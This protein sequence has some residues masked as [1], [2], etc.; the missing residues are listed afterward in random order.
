MG[1]LARTMSHSHHHH[2][3]DFKKAFTVTKEE[4]SQIKIVGEI[5]FAD[6]LH[7]RKAAIKAL[8]QHVSLDGFRKGHVPEPVLV[9]HIGEMNILAEM[10]ERAIAHMY[11]HILE[12]H[13]IDAIGYPKLEITKIAEGNPLGFTATVAVIP[14]IALPDYKSIAAKVNAEKPSLEVSEA[15]LDEK[16]NDIL[17]QKAAYERLQKSAATPVAVEGE[18]P[19]EEKTDEKPK[20]EIPELNDETVKTLGQPGQF[21][22]VEQ[23]KTMLREHLEIEKNRDVTANHRAAITDAIIEGSTIELPQILIDSELGQM[24]AQMEEDLKRSN[25]KLDDY[26]GHIKKT[27]EDLKKEWSPSAEKRAKLQLILNEIS[28]VEKII[29]DE[30]AINDQ[31][32]ELVTMYKDADEMRVRTYVAS[33]LT[34]EAVMKMLEEAK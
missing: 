17:R 21:E 19:T 4:K 12:A 11:P 30:K 15:E 13:D 29:A 6:L 14:E 16:I 32:T 33:V 1:T 18:D 22:T 20:L 27:K 9:K 3:I 25:L 10:A 28:K 23:F 5:P 2:D 26:L 8:G 7:E 34:N 31:V 24:F